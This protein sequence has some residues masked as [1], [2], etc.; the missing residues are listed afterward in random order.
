VK[1]VDTNGPL[2]L[3]CNDG[4][5]AFRLCSLRIP[6]I[7]TSVAAGLVTYAYELDSNE[8][9]ALSA[10]LD[11]GKFT[12]TSFRD[13][14]NKNVAKGASMDLRCEGTS[15][16]ATYTIPDTFYKYVP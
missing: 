6:A 9:K 16:R 11:G 4:A 10:A 8:A 12:A 7:V 5:E 3:Y 14:W 15:C 1:I 2:R 13:P